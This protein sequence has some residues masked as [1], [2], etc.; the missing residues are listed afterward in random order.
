VRAAAFGHAVGHRAYQAASLL[1]RRR[2]HRTGEI[3]VD[4][5]RTAQAG[6]ADIDLEAHDRDLRCGHFA[7]RAIVM[8]PDLL[9]PN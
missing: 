2:A 8:A 5:A 9:F 7:A 4:L 3:L 1:V 6:V